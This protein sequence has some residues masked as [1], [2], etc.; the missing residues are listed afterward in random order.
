L[1][2]ICE[3]TCSYLNTWSFVL[4]LSLFEGCW[5]VFKKWCLSFFVKVI[6]ACMASSFYTF[7]RGSYTLLYNPCFKSVFSLVI[8]GVLSFFGLFFWFLLLSGLVGLGFVF[9][10]SPFFLHATGRTVGNV[11]RWPDSLVLLYMRYDKSGVMVPRGGE[12]KVRD[13]V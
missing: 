10:S 4:F 5:E 7:F 2:G 3:C 12:S 1:F 11:T 8:L 6:A 9:F 13:D